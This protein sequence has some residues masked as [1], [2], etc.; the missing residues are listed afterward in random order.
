M[1]ETLQAYLIHHA[2]KP[3]QHYIDA[4]YLSAQ[5]LAKVSLEAG[6][7]FSGP[8]SKLQ[9]GS[10][11]AREQTGYDVSPVPMGRPQANGSKAQ[12]AWAMS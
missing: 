10:W 8:V 3:Q 6:I 11:Q 7:E 1:C 5:L 4:A 12:I 2:L 9:D